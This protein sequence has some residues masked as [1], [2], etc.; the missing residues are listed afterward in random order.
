MGTGHIT[1]LTTK[2]LCYFGGDIIQLT[3]MEVLNFSL[4]TVEKVW[5][6]S[7]LMGL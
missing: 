3:Q 2:A 6:A 1:C 7:E 4:I 5:H